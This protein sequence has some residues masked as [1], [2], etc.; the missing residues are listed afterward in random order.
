MLSILLV[1]SSIDDD[2]I[3]RVGVG[4]VGGIITLFFVG[5]VRGREG[6]ARFGGGGV[7]DVG[8]GEDVPLTTAAI[9]SEIAKNRI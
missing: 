8:D 6:R 1:S 7:E 4:G 3:S 5:V 2:G 9:V